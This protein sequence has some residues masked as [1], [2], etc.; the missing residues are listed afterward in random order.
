VG[1]RAPFLHDGCA[2]TLEERFQP[3]CGSNSH[4]SGGLTEGAITDLTAFLE[5]L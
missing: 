4:A 3:Q 2:Q 5:S 1:W